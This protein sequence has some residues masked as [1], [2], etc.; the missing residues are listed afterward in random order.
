[1][2]CTRFQEQTNTAKLKTIEYGD[3]KKPTWSFLCINTALKQAISKSALDK[4]NSRQPQGTVTTLTEK[5]Q[6]T[7]QITVKFVGKTEM[8]LYNRKTENN[9]LSREAKL[10]Q[11]CDLS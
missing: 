5:P 1:M 10:L 7:N 8:A 11:C 2:N 3:P 4:E 6:I 9:C